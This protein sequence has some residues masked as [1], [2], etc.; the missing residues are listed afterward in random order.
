MYP[1]APPT[2]T[3]I[4]ISIILLVAAVA[5]LEF[6]LYLKFKSEY[7]KTGR[8]A[9]KLGT[10]LLISS[11]KKTIILVPRFI[12]LYLIMLLPL[13]GIVYYN[14]ELI[15]PHYRF[16]LAELYKTLASVCK[17]ER[18]YFSKINCLV[19]MNKVTL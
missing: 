9:L 15:Y 2:R 7:G 13:L 18:L 14:A 12:L 6:I 17:N 5:D 3:E 16:S 1:P 10:N 11:F 8:E 4:I 19:E